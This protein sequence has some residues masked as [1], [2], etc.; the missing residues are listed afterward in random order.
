MRLRIRSHRSGLAANAL[1]RKGVGKAL[2]TQVVVPLLSESLMLFVQLN[3]VHIVIAHDGAA[4]L[5]GAGV[6]VAPILCEAPDYV[7]Q[8]LLDRGTAA[9]MRR[10]RLREST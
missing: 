10:L 4:P 1:V 2:Q 5:L 6:I 3:Q 8:A 9:F 7:K